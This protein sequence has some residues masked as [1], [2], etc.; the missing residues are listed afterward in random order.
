MSK[1]NPAQ[2]LRVAFGLVKGEKPQAAWRI[3]GMAG[4]AAVAALL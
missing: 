2:V 3:S 4:R 1:R